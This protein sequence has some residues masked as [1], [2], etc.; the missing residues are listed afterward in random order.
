MSFWPQKIE[1]KEVWINSLGAAIAWIVWS[2]ILFL[3]VVS[4]SKFIN[5][6]DWF[7]ALQA[8]AWKTNI[9]FPLVLSAIAFIA[10]SFTIFVTYFFLY[11]A[12]P[13]RYRKSFVI[14]GQIAFFTF[15]SYLFFVP[16]YIYAG[17]IDYNYIIIVFLLHAILV[18]F[19][20][21]LI[22]E[23]LNNY[24]YIL[25]S[26]YWSFIGLYLTFIIISLVFFNIEQ[27]SAKLIALLFLLPLINLLQVFFKSLFDFLYFHY[28]RLTN[29][30][31]VWDIFYQIELEEKEAL[32]EE[33]EKNSI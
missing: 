13:D 8:G 18:I 10:I 9:I 14:F 16:A 2:I 24:R 15:L 1:L 5:I 19:W 29:L 28:N 31:Q 20:A 27:N 33:E 3:I 11:F 23:I 22:I 12:N 30:D 4:I 7:Q 21:N 26:L 25:V 17:S 32:K 6:M